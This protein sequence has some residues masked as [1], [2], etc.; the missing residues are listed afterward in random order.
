MRDSLFLDTALLPSIFKINLAKTLVLFG[1][2]FFLFGLLPRWLFPQR[3]AGAGLEKSISNILYML[4]FF[5]LVVPLMEELGIFSLFSLLSA[6]V[7]IKLL[8]LR[9]V[10]KE[11][12]MHLLEKSK[13]KTLMEF[14]NF[15]DDP[16]GYIAKIKKSLIHRLYT[17]IL[18]WHQTL[19]SRLFLLLL[20]LTLL[21]YLGY[22]CFISMSN[23][24]PDTAQ[25]VEWVANLQKGILYA[26]NKTA[27]A[28]FYGLAVF[29]FVLQLFTNI[30][31]LILF[32]I[33]PLL[34]ITFLLFGLYFVVKRFTLSWR[35]AAWSVMIYG[36]VLVGSPFNN[37]L[38][39]PFHSTTEPEIIRFLF[40]KLYTLPK[41]WLGG[42]SGPGFTP[43]LR[44]FSGMAYEFASAFF[45]LNLYYLIHAIQ[46]GGRTKD[47]I[48]YSLTLLLVFIFHGGGAIALSVPSIFIAL[49]AF[50]SK[51]LS[52]TLFKKGLLAIGVAAIFGNGWMLS[53]LKYGIPQDFGAAAPFLDR[54]FGTKQAL[55][56]MVATGIEEVTVSYLTPTQLY[57]FLAIVLL[58][59]LARIHKK[60]FYFASFLLIPLGVFFIYFSEN[61]GFFK[62]IYQDRAA[63]YLLL[64]VV[65]LVACAIK[66]LFV[67][68]RLLVPRLYR[69]LFIPLSFVALLLL[70]LFVPHY[71][72]SPTLMRSIDPLNYSSI[73]WI[74]HII[75]K[76]NKPYTWSVVSFVEEY[77]QVLGKGYFINSQEFITRYDPINPNLPKQKIFIFV[78]DIPHTAHLSDA[79]YY[80]WRTQITDN[81]KAWIALYGST[82]RNIRL[83]KKSTLISVYEIDNTQGATK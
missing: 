41:E 30:D 64:S 59:L 16:R 12:L 18:R 28:D 74:L 60:G 66:L 47:L 52:K 3:F 70:A 23:P 1:V 80:R 62:L 82:H 38:L 20:A 78:E 81:L 4:A 22:R 50:L 53:V 42:V 55:E 44:Y 24:L 13:E 73:S 72:D 26:D 11:R 32:N 15:L 14:F 69:T 19:P 71:K 76:E 40:F 10:E 57:L 6:M 29:V 54:L 65:I 43:Y 67:P 2:A 36:L 63:E 5:E 39:P 83:W 49:H 31:S 56:D 8:F 17:W 25:F 33:Y 68:F 61:L 77:P 58:F 37:L 21:Y 27:G 48:N 9:L 51:K 7:G 46:T 79:W 75:K 34:L 35:V 45:L